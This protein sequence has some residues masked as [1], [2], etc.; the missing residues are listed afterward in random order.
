MSHLPPEMIER[1][2]AQC[3]AD[4]AARGLPPHITD[5][6]TLDRIVSIVVTPSN[7][8]APETTNTNVT[9]NE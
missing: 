9:N 7:T 3:R 2:L 5:Q 8:T 4:D 6:A 1:F